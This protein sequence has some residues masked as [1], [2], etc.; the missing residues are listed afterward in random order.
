MTEKEKTVTTVIKKNLPK[1]YLQTVFLKIENI[2]TLKEQ[3]TAEVFVRARWRETKLDNSTPQFI[4]G[5]DWDKY[6]DPRL[7]LGN[8]KGELKETVWRDVQ[9]GID[10]EAY[11]LEMRRATGTFYENLELE[12]FP[13]DTQHLSVLITSEH[14]VTS[15]ELIEEHEEASSVYTLNFGD[16]QEWEMRDFV[17]C[18]SKITPIEYSE[19]RYK[20]PGMFFTC[21]AF[22]K[23]GYFIWNILV[24][25]FLISFMSLGT[26]S[27]DRTS[28]ETRL[29][30]GFTLILTTVTFKLVAAR[31]LPMISYLTHLDIY[32]L[33]STLFLF[34]VCAWHALI[35]AF[36]MW[37]QTAEILD[38][39]MLI[40]L[41]V[42]FILMQ[43]SFGVAMVV[44][45]Y[46]NRQV[47]KSKEYD[48]QQKVKWTLGDRPRT[49]R[50]HF[51]PRSSKQKIGITK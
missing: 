3:F 43:L 2:D 5:I 7:Q 25:M 45:S 44:R 28:H 22:R 14:P 13:F 20:R 51:G 49:S 9:I 8:Y 42:I 10:G 12:E 18:R 31:S 6:W 50:R 34:V 39:I 21:C 47:I 32:I 48:Y 37:P 41:S 27:V 1:V 29:S 16:I 36:G 40:G 11:V 46:R 33:M 19:N 4:I 17:E 35:P 30:L 26:F 38:Y 23:P 24:V 15:V